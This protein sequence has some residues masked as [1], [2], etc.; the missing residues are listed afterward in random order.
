MTIRHFFG[1]VA[2]TLLLSACALA[3]EYTVTTVA[4][5]GTPGFLDG[6]GLGAQLDGPDFL[7]FGKAGL[8]ISDSLNQRIRLFTGGNVSTIIGDGTQGYTGDGGAALSAELSDPAGM[9]LD[10]AGNLYIS[11]FK[12]NVVRKVTTSG[13]ISTVAGNQGT[14]AGYTGDS[15]AAT[16]A[17]LFGPL[18]VAVDSAGNI[19]IADSTNNVIREVTASNSNIITYV[20]SAQGTLNNPYGLVLDAAGN[21][22]IADEGNNRV[23]KYAANG[24]GVTPFTN[25]AGNGTA[26]YSGDGGPATEAMLDHPAGLAIDAQGNILIAEDAV[27]GR[28]RRVSPTTGI[29]TTIAGNGRPGYS[30]D[31]GIATA[32]EFE[33]PRAIA[34]DNSTGNIYIGDTQYAVIRML[35]PVPSTPTI[36][37]KGITN[38]AGFTA[39][40]SPGS[41]A[42]I[43]GGGFALAAAQARTY[44]YP[45][46][47]S[48]ISVSV[49]GKLAPIYYVSA[50]Q[51]NF[52]VPWETPIGTATVAVTV[53]NVTG[54]AQTVQV[55]PAAPGLFTVGNIQAAAI[56][57]DGNL[58]SD[59]DPANSGDTILVYAT[60]LGPVTLPQTD[61]VPAS[62]TSLAYDSLTCT[63][64]IGSTPV[65]VPFCGLAPGYVGLWQV[66]VVIPSALAPADYP[67]VLTVNGQSSNQAVISVY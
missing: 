13:T 60:G 47:L 55:V 45:T 59:S 19:Y 62:T 52:Q 36:A 46:E 41:L 38:A 9:A 5:N 4:G 48:N 6:T 10:S 14:G 7:L 54:N 3:Q 20:G 31:G 30:G 2:S 66:N 29:I 40:I 11:D 34:V 63:A 58:N 61:G 26:G 12:N 32:A 67:L 16:A 64:S 39:P 53:N 15:G 37:A 65:T 21:L 35:Q 17:Q 51:I 44:P 1:G 49:N 57:P 43:F 50:T 27:T 24:A 23:A 56:N 42:S 25:F 8:Y 28:I 18:G 22:Y 33:S